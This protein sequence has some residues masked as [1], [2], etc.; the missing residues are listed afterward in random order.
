MNLPTEIWW[1][2]ILPKLDD[3]TLIN[4][5]KADLV[6]DNELFWKKRIEQHWV[7]NVVYPPKP[8]MA[9]YLEIAHT[10]D[11]FI[12]PFTGAHIELTHAAKGSPCKTPYHLSIT[13]TSDDIFSRK[14]ILCG[15]SYINRKWTER[16]EVLEFHDMCDLLNWRVQTIHSQ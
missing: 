2:Q 9:T 1:Y 5:I 11:E 7:S 3:I 12:K 6:D 8:S 16:F 14:T 4:V 15:P 10:W 13:Q